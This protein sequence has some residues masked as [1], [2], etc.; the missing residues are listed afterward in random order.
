MDGPPPDAI[1]ASVLG[2][3]VRPGGSEEVCGTISWGAVGLL[4]LWSWE[5]SLPVWGPVLWPPGRRSIGAVH[6]RLHPLVIRTRRDAGV[7]RLFPSPAGGPWGACL[8]CVRGGCGFPCS[9]GA[10]SAEQ[11]RETACGPSS[12]CSVFVGGSR[13]SQARNGGRG[14]RLS[15]GLWRFLSEVSR[16]RTV[17]SPSCPWAATWL[18]R[19]RRWLDSCL[20]RD[21]HPRMPASPSAVKS[22]ENIESLAWFGKEYGK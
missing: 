16:G 10:G 9:P 1:P 15:R 7:Q 2:G 4:G 5:V 13:R 3:G 6:G 22:G 18:R 21:K 19:A 12:P 14:R 8:V 17:T 20:L 11:P